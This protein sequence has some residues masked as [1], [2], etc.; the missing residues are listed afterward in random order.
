MQ[1]I[2]RLVL[3]FSYEVLFEEVQ[4]VVVADG[5]FAHL[6]QLLS[7]CALVFFLF[8]LLLVLGGFKKFF[9]VHFVGPSAFDVR[10]PRVFDVLALCVDRVF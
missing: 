2:G 3:A 6:H 4:N 7:G 1:R 8:H 5:C 10:H 9:A